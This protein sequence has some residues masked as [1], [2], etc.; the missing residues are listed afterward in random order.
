MHDHKKQRQ[1]KKKIEKRIPVEIYRIPTNI[2]TSTVTVWTSFYTR[3]N[4][5]RVNPGRTSM[6][7]D[8]N[9]NHNLNPRPYIIIFKS[10]FRHM[11]TLHWKYQTTYSITSNSCL[12]KNL[13][14]PYQ[15]HHLMG[16]IPPQD[17]YMPRE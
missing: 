8:Q 13:R 9:C 7:F 14:F 2:Q 3:T 4:E 5:S 6:C 10:G 15:N 12:H 1:Q 16:Q 11:N 17:H